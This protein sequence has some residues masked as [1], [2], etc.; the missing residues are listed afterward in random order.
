MELF[1]A[2]RQWASRPS[3]ERFG[4]LDEMYQVTRRYAEAARTKNMPLSDLR[5]EDSDGDLRVIGRAGVPARLTHYAFGQLAGRVGA[6]AGYLRTLP[7][8][9][10]ATNVNYGLARTPDTGVLMFHTNGDLVLRCVTSEQY[11]RIWNYEVI[12]RLRDACGRLDLEPA[13]PTFR[14][15]NGADINGDPRPALWASDHDMFAF[16]M[17]RERDLGVAGEPGLFR[18]AFVWNSEVGDRSL[19]LMTFLFRDVCGN[20][21]VWGAEKAQ[22]IRVIHRGDVSGRWSRY[23]A[24]VRQ[25]LDSPTGPDVERVTSAKRFL[26][27]ADKEK[28]LDALFGKGVASRRLLEAAY[29][30]VVPEEDGDPRTAWGIAQGV[31]RHS[32]TLPYG[33]ARVETDRVA[34]R[35]LEFAF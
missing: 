29:D 20:F 3:D 17:S 5:V 24:A 32:Q 21:I 14:Q 28:V 2:S 12:G 6:P 9:L 27:G 8:T 10:A 1:H 25:Y 16:V 4:T 23:E 19:G 15:F 34:A 13:R 11:A 7:A 31:T 35:I 26:L 22:E 33:D 18:G 30:A